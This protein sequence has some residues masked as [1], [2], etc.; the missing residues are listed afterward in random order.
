MS[1]TAEEHGTFATLAELVTHCEG[2]DCPNHARE[3]EGVK[4]R[5]IEAAYGDRDGVAEAARALGLVPTAI[6]VVPHGQG[7][8]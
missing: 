3:W 8:A 7:V 5:I 2:G 4:E 1:E 6:E